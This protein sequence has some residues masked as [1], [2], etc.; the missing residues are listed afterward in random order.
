MKKAVVLFSG[1]IDS[2]VVLAMALSHYQECLALSFDYGQKHRV[3]LEHAK[4]IAKHY[5]VPHKIITID[6]TCFENTALVNDICLPTH[7]TTEEIAEGGIPSTYV[8][9][10]NTL[11]LAFATGQAE[12]HNAQ[13]IHCGPNLSD[14][15]PYPD[16]RPK[17]Y[18]AFQHVIN[19]A[20][21]QSVTGKPPEII[22]PLIHW[23]KR[24]I[25]EEAVKLNVPLSLTFSCYQPK[26]NH[27]CGI[28]DACVLRCE[29]LR[30]TQAARK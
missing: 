5:N 6:P 9:A 14:Q 18:Q 28:C 30:Y 12:I 23:D 25:V 21:K 4:S 2:T 8:P 15:N 16:C 29:A 11:F 1:G 26:E 10:R 22:T 3:E 24:R 17:F 20:T 27:P 7:R 19:T 13:E